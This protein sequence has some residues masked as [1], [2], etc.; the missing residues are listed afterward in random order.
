MNDTRKAYIYVRSAVD[1]PAIEDQLEVT[2]QCCR[3]LDLEVFG[4]YVESRMAEGFPARSQMIRDAVVGH[5]P[6][7]V[8]YSAATLFQNSDGFREVDGVL[9]RNGIVVVPVNRLPD[10]PSK[11][12]IIDDHSNLSFTGM[13]QL[14]NVAKGIMDEL[15]ARDSPEDDAPE[16]V[17]EPVAPVAD[18]AEAEDDADAEDDVGTSKFADPTLPEGICVGDTPVVID[19]VIDPEWVRVTY[20]GFISLPVVKVGTT[21]P[22]R[23]EDNGTYIFWGKGESHGDFVVQEIRL[24][25]DYFELDACLRSQAGTPGEIVIIPRC[26]YVKGGPGV[27]LQECTDRIK[28]VAQY[29]G[30]V[31]QL[32]NGWRFGEPSYLG[33]VAINMGGVRRE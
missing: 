26:A 23:D 29:V 18:S 5:V 4:Y 27:S 9:G 21:D 7:I 20:S 8:T 14:L 13:L 30:Y 28:A 11:A 19:S 32:N 12:E 3:D 24:T 31:L 1:L 17:S 15:R 16:D 33:G 2:R 22:A 10:I 6:N 25:V